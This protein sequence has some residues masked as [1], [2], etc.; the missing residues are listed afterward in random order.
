MKETNRIRKIVRLKQLV[1]RW[2]RRIPP[3]GSFAVY[4][5]DEHEHRQFVIPIRFINLPVFASLLNKAEEAFGFQTNSGLVLPCDAIFFEK[6]LKA[7]ERNERRF[8]AL[9]LGDFTEMF[10]ESWPLIGSLLL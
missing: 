5:G 6:L 9:D 2:R 7:L 8:G 1:Q 3:G 10:S 4:V